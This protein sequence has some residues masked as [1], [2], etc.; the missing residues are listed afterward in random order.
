M[1][2]LT[3]LNSLQKLVDLA[4]QQ[5]HATTT[6]LQ[7]IDKFQQVPV[8]SEALSIQELVLSTTALLTNVNTII[9][10]EMGNMYSDKTFD[11]T[12]NG[13]GFVM[14]FE[15]IVHSVNLEELDKDYRERPDGEINEEEDEED[16]DNPPTT[17]G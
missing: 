5:S 13:G 12:F 7:A 11:G 1:S 4:T 2:K 16:D 10:E 8:I 3:E 6:F 15:N 17:S 9:S 14:P